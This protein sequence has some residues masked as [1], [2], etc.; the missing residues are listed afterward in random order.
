MYPHADATPIDLTPFTRLEGVVDVIYNP[1]KTRLVLQAEDMG[2]KA[3]GGLYML[4]AQALCAAE[5]F[6]REPLPKEKMEEI[7]QAVEKQKQNMVLLG[8]DAIPLGQKLAEKMGRPWVDVATVGLQEAAARTGVVL[9][10]EGSA[11]KDSS[12]LLALRQNGIF[13]PA[14]KENEIC[15]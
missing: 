12:V 13:I 7:F 1:L 11:A 14:G 10:V 3:S 8:T 15:F 5:H 6:L 9:S 2:I 4:V